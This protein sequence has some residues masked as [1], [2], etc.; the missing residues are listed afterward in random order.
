MAGCRLPAAC[1]LLPI[2]CRSFFLLVSVPSFCV[3]ALVVPALIHFTSLHFTPSPSTP[4][5]TSSTSAVCARI[6][7]STSLSPLRAASTVARNT[8]TTTP[9]AHHGL[10]SIPN[11]CRGLQSRC[12]GR[13]HSRRSRKLY[14]RYLP[15]KLV[16]LGISSL[17]QRQHGF[18]HSLR[19]FHTGLYRSRRLQQRMARL[20]HRHGV[21]VYSRGCWLCW[22]SVGVQ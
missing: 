15:A 10:H 18:H 12:A 1:C 7:S 19:S 8:G 22:K 2:A 14:L 11:A 3:S 16:V 17:L 20:H 9:V 21:R 13:K 6:S 5:F 4:F